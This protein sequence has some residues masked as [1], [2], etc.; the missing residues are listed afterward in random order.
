MAN[1]IRF[2]GST[3]MKIA[4]SD[5]SDNHAVH[6]DCTGADVGKTY[7]IILTG[8]GDSNIYGIDENGIKN[9]I[10]ISDITKIAMDAQTNGSKNN[11]AYLVMSFTATAPDFSGDIT[12][13]KFFTASKLHAI[14]SEYHH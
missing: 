12:F 11:I 4:F 14:I 5:S 2:G 10:G 1:I 13:G 3:E 6:F 8:P 7:Y 9:G